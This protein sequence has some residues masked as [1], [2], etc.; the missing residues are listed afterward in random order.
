MNTLLYA[1]LNIINL[2]IKYHGVRLIGSHWNVDV[3]SELLF[4]Q[5]IAIY[6][7]FYIF[8][9]RLFISNNDNK[10]GLNGL[11]KTEAKDI[12]T[13]MLIITMSYLGSTIC[14]L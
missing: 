5:F 2:T 12:L 3:M 4:T 11:I 8:V 10:V 9:L 14:Y 6:L 7:V 1:V 13:T